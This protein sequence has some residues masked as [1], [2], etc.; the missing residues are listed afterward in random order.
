VEKLEK[1][2][3]F[4][5]A[6]RELSRLGHGQ[7]RD[8]GIPRSEIVHVARKLVYAERRDAPITASRVEPSPI[9]DAFEHARAA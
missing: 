3:A 9:E 7:L 2:R 4:R 1:D 8:I 6:V 5:S